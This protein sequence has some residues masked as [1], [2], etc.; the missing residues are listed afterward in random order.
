M[1]CHQQKPP[2]QFDFHGK[3]L[4]TMAAWV[5][6]TGGARSLLVHTHPGPIPITPFYRHLPYLPRR[7]SH[8]SCQPPLSHLVV[9]VACRHGVSFGSWPVRLVDEGHTSR[10]TIDLSNNTLTI[11]EQDELFVNS[12]RAANKPLV[13]KSHTIRQLVGL[14]STRSTVLTVLAHIILIDLHKLHCH[15]SSGLCSIIGERNDRI[16]FVL[17]KNTG[18]KPTRSKH[19]TTEN[20]MPLT[21]M[22]SVVTLHTTLM[23]ILW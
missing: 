17:W 2:T 20:T 7:I 15:P 5:M 13:D 16:L 6:P 9:Q 3:H 14:L 1:W 11:H 21:S 19:R 18:A 10:V 8:E 22:Q 12:F 4:R 23:Q